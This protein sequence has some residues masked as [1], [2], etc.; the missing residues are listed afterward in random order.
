MKAGDSRR[1]SGACA[2]IRWQ[3]LGRLHLDLIRRLAYVGEIPRRRIAHNGTKDNRAR[4]E[5]GVLR[6]LNASTHRKFKKLGP[7][8]FQTARADCA[9]QR[10]PRKA[11]VR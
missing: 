7:C 9:A 3:A 2:T 6:L 5:L 1:V 10:V 4:G 11:I 8:Q